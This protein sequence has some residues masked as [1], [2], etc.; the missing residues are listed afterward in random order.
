[1]ASESRSFFNDVTMGFNI[2]NNYGPNIEV[3]DGGRVTL[4]QGHNGL[5]HTGDA[6]EAEYEEVKDGIVTQED[7]PRSVPD[8][9][10]TETAREIMQ[11]LVDA[12]LLSA[13]WQ[14]LGLSGAERGLVASAVCKRLEIAE[15]WQVFGRLWNEK[16][17]TLR[18]YLNKAY[19]QK[20]SLEFQDRLK[21]ILG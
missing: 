21:K 17:E 9:L 11:L 6:E 18:S 20:K 10:K 3:N 8:S 2:K 14:P 19:N 15:V 1:M 4:V 7:C 5:W 13:D 12:G 16:P